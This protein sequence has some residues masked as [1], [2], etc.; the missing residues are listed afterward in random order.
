MKTKRIISLF[1]AVD[2]V[3]LAPFHEADPFVSQ[4]VRDALDQVR[5]GIID[6]TIDIDDIC[7]NQYVYLPLIL[8]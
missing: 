5:Q 6:G 1:A 4:D 3:G 8:K 7:R 2:G